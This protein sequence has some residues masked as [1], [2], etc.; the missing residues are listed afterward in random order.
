MNEKIKIFVSYSHQNGDWIDKGG[1]Y[2]LVPWLKKQLEQNNVVFWTDHKLQNHIGEEYKKKIKENIDNSD[3]ALLMISQEFATSEFITKFELPWIKEAFESEK[4]KIIP[5]LLTKLSKQGKKNI[6]WLFELQTIPNDNKP[7]IEYSDND[8]NW[9]DIMI[10][11]LDAIESKIEYVGNERTFDEQPDK[12]QREKESQHQENI[13]NEIQLKIQTIPEN[14]DVYI[15]GRFIQKTPCT[16][17]NLIPNSEI[18]IEIKKEGYETKEI[19]K[20]YETSGN[21]ELDVKLDKLGI[22]LSMAFVEG[23]TF[24]MGGTVEQGND[25]SNNEKPTRTVTLKDYYISKYPITQ[26]QWKEIMGSNPSNFTKNEENPVENVNW[27][28]IQ[29]FVKKLNEKTGKKYRLPTEAEWEY[30]CRG[31]K[32][33]AHYKYGG[34]NSIGEVAWY[35]DNSENKTHKVG[36]KKANE[37]GIYDMSGNVY[38]WVRDIYGNYISGDQINPTG[39][40]SGSYHIFRG[41]SYRCSSNMCRV[42][43]RYYASPDFCSGDL[44]FRLVLLEK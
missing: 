12:E 6:E 9:H 27:D 37:L 23:G 11:I 13:A 16:I 39:A 44:G 14:T 2:N 3:I 4:I 10:T 29:I 35:K 42:S 1:K 15:W 25:C 22:G 7:L 34:S 28:M 36:T 17:S 19:T 31:G 40:K 32:Y 18:K 5:L 20:C 30:A 43:F 24:T 8:I 26:K 33:S 38:E 21:K 41:G